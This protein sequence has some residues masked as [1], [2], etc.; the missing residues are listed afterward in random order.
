M[1]EARYGITLGYEKDTCSI[2]KKKR[3]VRYIYDRIEFLVVRVCDGCAAKLKDMPIEEAVKR[4][5]EKTSKKHIDILTKEQMKK[6][7]FD[8]KGLKDK[9]A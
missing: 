2:C 5:G 3:E 7:G 8:M 4:Y 9:A 1:S 6:S